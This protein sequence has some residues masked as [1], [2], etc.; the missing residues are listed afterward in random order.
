MMYGVAAKEVAK[1]YNI[2][3]NNVDVI[4]WRVG[5][6][7]RKYGPRHFEAALRHEGYGHAA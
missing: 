2:K 4:T 5:R 1:K 3:A 6:L 7:I